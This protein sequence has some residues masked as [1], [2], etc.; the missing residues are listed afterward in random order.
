MTGEG[1]PGKECGANP[2]GPGRESGEEGPGKAGEGSCCVSLPSTAP[3]S[4]WPD[5]LRTRAQR[6][7]AEAKGQKCRGLPE[8]KPS[9]LKPAHGADPLAFCRIP[10]PEERAGPTDLL[11]PC[12]GSEF[13]MVRPHPSTCLGF[14]MLF[15]CKPPA[16]IPSPRFVSQPGLQPRD[17]W[18]A[19]PKTLSPREHPTLLR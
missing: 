16:T 3:S 19:V 17:S 10:Y 15:L 12:M 5:L 2:M 4:R 8:L 13:R 7:R 14:H 6:R 1:A 18:F 9:A 11:R